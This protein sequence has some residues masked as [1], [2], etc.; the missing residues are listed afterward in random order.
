MT[1]GH[2]RRQ[3]RRRG[4][5]VC[6]YRCPSSLVGHE[7]ELQALHVFPAPPPPPHGGQVGV[8]GAVGSVR[9]G[10]GLLQQLHLGLEGRAGDQGRGEGAQ[11]RRGFVVALQA[12]GGGGG[13]NGFGH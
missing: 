1:P 10:R 13:R 11:R 4:R 8:Q 5:A 9:Q 2:A 7:E 12:L 3:R 6:A